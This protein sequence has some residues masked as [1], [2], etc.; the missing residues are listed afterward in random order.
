[1]AT[2]QDRQQYLAPHNVND[3]IECGGQQKTG[4]NGA[5]TLISE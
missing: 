2:Q 4:E 3:D 5:A 1:M